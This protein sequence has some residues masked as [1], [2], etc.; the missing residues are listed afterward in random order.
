MKCENGDRVRVGK[1]LQ[2]GLVDIAEDRL[3]VG[4]VVDVIPGNLYRDAMYR[5]RFDGKTTAPTLT[6]TPNESWIDE[7]QVYDTVR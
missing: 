6:P 7:G 2:S 3:M 4:I 1:R 5:V